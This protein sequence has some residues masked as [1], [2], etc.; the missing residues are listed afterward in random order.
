[1]RTGDIGLFKL[2]AESGV[3][4]GVRRVEALTGQG[5]LEAI[6]RREKILE[7]IGAHLGARDARRSNA[8]RN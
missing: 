7:D 8:S 3:A 4:A 5:A 2:E 6:R 1:M